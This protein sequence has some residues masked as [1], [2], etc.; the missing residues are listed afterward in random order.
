MSQFSSCLEKDEETKAAPS[1]QALSLIQVKE[2]ETENGNEE[3][4]ARGNVVN[5]L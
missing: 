3:A 1:F 4:K 2:D 5:L